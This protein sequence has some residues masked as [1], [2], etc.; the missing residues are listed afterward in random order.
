MVFSVKE[1]FAVGSL[2]GQGADIGS[3]ECKVACVPIMA[4]VAGFGVLFRSCA[5]N[6][7]SPKEFV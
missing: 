6:R 2:L 3:L 5:P 1:F 4:C 7:C